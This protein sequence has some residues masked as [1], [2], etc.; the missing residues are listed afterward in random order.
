MNVSCRAGRL[1]GRRASTLVIVL[2]IALGLVALGLYFGQSSALN[3]R[4]SDHRAAALEAEQAIQG[5]AR[6]AAFVVTNLDTPGVLPQYTVAP[7]FPPRVQNVPVGDAAFWFLGRDVDR[8]SSTLG[9][10]LQPT[11]GLVDEASKLNLNTATQE[12]LELLPRMT[13]QLAAAI[14]DWRDENDEPSAD[15]AEEE[16]YQRLT[17]PYRCKNA[18]FESI[19][20]LRLV[21]GMTMDVLLGEDANLNGILD[22]NEDDYDAAAPLDNRDGRLD[23]GLW[24]FVTVHSRDGLTTTNGTARIPVSAQGR[25][26][27]ASLLQERLGNQR[28][29]EVLGRLGNQSPPGLLNFF[30]LSGMTVDEFVQVEDSLTA[31][32][33]Q[34]PQEGLVNVNTAPEAV[35]ACLPGIGTD[36]APLLVSYRQSNPNRRN[37]VA[38]AAEILGTQRSQQA[39]R[40]LTGRSSVYGADVCAVGHL[41]RGYRRCRM[42]LDASE[43]GLRIVQRTDLS[44]LGWALGSQ[45]WQ[46]QQQQRQWTQNTR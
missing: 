39:G 18:P 45:T 42:I 4:A 19:E 2:W 11:F 1:L 38:W 37:T 32:D 41:G 12:M 23:S 10:N 14:I 46:Q 27:L 28:A 29:N 9:R 7:R 5:A 31:G 44:H 8:L 43:G 34:A 6:Y 35:L 13:P 22:P 25:Q 24:E 17:P 3:L 40:Y 36:M 15:G 26:Q 33:G 30:V 21:Y 20:E 16:T